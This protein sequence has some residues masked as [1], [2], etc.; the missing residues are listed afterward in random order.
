M[1]VKMEDVT[2]EGDVKFLTIIQKHGWHVMHVRNRAGEIEPEFSYST[3]IYEKFGTPELIIFGLTSELR[4]SM[5][6]G[7]GN[8]IAE[9]LRKFYSGEFYDGFLEG[10]D[11]YLTEGNFRLKK[12]Y[13]CWADWYYERQPFPL[14]QCIW[15]TTSGVWPW[16]SQA[17]ADVKAMQPIFG[18][19]PQDNQE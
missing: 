12:E 10:F 16:D 8:E 9:N 4:Q 15:P 18:P 19:T 13:A 11:I 14:L 2:D 6:N 3:G 7:Y 5:I 17:S 1:V